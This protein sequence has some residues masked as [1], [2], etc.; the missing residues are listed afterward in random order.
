M[1]V[2]R[3]AVNDVVG[4]IGRLVE[5]GDAVSTVLGDSA[6]ADTEP[7]IGADDA[8]TAACAVGRRGWAGLGTASANFDGGGSALVFAGRCRRSRRHCIPAGANPSSGKWGGSAL[9]RA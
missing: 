9:P 3:V 5:V 2:D 8:V 4:Q 7:E 6:V 1:P